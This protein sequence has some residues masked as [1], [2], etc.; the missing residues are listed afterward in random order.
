[1]EWSTKLV[2]YSIA[3]TLLLSVS[4]PQAFAQNFNSQTHLNMRFQQCAKGSYKNSKGSCVKR[5]AKAPSWPA[6]ASAKCWDDTYSYSQSR[7]GTCSHHGGVATWRSW[8]FE[9]RK[10]KHKHFKQ[11]SYF[12]RPKVWN[13]ALGIHH[14]HAVMDSWLQDVRTQ[15]C[16]LGQSDSE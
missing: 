1:M 13:W 9:S 16:R 4:T 8:F 15:R 11:G 10:I 2:S 5:P 6:G 3:L 12:I 7:R 14:F